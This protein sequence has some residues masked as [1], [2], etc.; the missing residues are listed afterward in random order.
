MHNHLD[1]QKITDV[2][3]DPAKQEAGNLPAQP[4][5]NESTEEAASNPVQ[6]ASAEGAASAE[7]SDSNLQR[8]DRK[9]TE[10]E[11]TQ[12]KPQKTAETPDQDAEGRALPGEKKKD[13]KRVARKQATRGKRRK[14]IIIALCVLVLFAAAAIGMRYYI[15]AEQNALEVTFYHL[16][17]NNVGSGFRVVQLSDLHLHEFG[18]KNK[19]LVDWIRRLSPDIITITGDMNNHFNDDIHVVTELCSQLTEIANV[20]YVMG[21]HEWVDYADRKTS[22]KDDIIATGVTML[23]NSFEEI[24][25][26]G[27]KVVIG[28]LVNE[29]SNY[30]KY[31]GPKF[32]EKFMKADGFKILLVHYPEYFLGTLNHYM[33]DLV[34]CGHT[35]GG[36]IR[37]PRLGGLYASDQGFLPELYEGMQ[38]VSGGSVVVVS[39]GLGGEGKIP[40]INNN[41]ELVVVDVNWY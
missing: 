13:K 14:R 40:R 24:Q 33:I 29:V 39:R 9:Q 4:A 21:N 30:Q 10:P 3:Q 19:E 2:P 12:E 37:I 23:Q 32:M 7:Q 41:P 34:M 36:I 18:K 20:Y 26:N 8:E 27:N 16:Q 31:S 22:I 5:K 17:S 25:V 11:S 15:K 38:T 6:S 35:H 1:E 28:G